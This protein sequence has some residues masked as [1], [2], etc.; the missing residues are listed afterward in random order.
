MTPYPCTDLPAKALGVLYTR[1]SRAPA[2]SQ[3]LPGAQSRRVWAALRSKVNWEVG[4][5][6]LGCPSSLTAPCA[7]EVAPVRGRFLSS[8]PKLVFWAS[9]VGD[10]PSSPETGPLGW[11]AQARGSVNLFNT[12]FAEKGTWKLCSRKI[13]GWMNEWTNECFLWTPPWTTD[14]WAHQEALRAPPWPEFPQQR[15]ERQH[16]RR[17]QALPF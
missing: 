6:V 5:A 16:S 10:S 12:L 3:P 4:L 7:G 8:S 15:E 13:C 11:A 1:D 17:H 2:V 14:L 9:R